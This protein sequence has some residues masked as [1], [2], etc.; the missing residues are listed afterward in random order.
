MLYVSHEHIITHSRIVINREDTESA[1]HSVALLQQRLCYTRAMEGILTTSV[2]V[3]NEKE[4]ERRVPK[5]RKN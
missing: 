3:V 5:T 4:R 2:R 1:G